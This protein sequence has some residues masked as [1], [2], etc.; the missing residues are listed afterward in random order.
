[1]KKA[2]TS[3]SE[4]ISV[5]LQ[6]KSLVFLQAVNPEDQSIYSTALSWI[7]ATSPTTI[8]FA[9]DSK[10][11]LIDLLAKNPHVTLNVVADES[12]HAI[13]GKAQLK[14]R[15]AEGISIHLALLE[16]SVEEVRDI[17]FFGGKI[18][19]EPAFIKTYDQKLIDKLDNEVSEAVRLL[20]E[21]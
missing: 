10:S 21:Q 7:Y 19:T 20:V 18:V 12:T 5:Q 6:G 16:I 2:A 9:I 15:K 3:L 4:A 8:H 13:T 1:M 11:Q 14:E 17:M